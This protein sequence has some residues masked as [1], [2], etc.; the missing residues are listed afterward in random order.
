M[1]NYCDYIT[2]TT[3]MNK[4]YIIILSL[5]LSLPLS[6]QVEKKVIIEHFTNT[7]CG[8]CANKNPALYETLGEYPQLLH[9][10]YHP[11][12][13]Y[14]DCVF[15]MHNP[16]ENDERANYYNVFGGTP[17]A[18][19]QGVALPVQT[20]LVNTSNIEMQLGMTSDFKVTIDNNQVSGDDHKVNVQIERVSVTHNEEIFVYIALAEK[21]ISYNAPNGETM[22]YDVFR[23]K[24]TEE[25]IDLVSVGSMVN[26]VLGYSM[27]PDWNPN[28]IYAYI[29]INSTLSSEVLQSESSLTSISGI[30]NNSVVEV[31]NILYPNPASSTLNINIAYIDKVEKIELY[32]ILGNKVKAFN[33]D[34][35][36]DI[37][38][39]VDGIYFARITDKNSNITSARIIKGQ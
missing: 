5:L 37:S 39:L 33:T 2:K 30:Y 9:I 19:I 25:I 22:H 38:D 18:V 17:R 15:S 13:P 6:A 34:D 21:E 8:I 31:K 4:F 20:P 23:K 29:V 36:M 10:A 24:L 14:A 16:A 28:E 1:L 26:Y 3:K 32:S 12:A 7:K 35:I 11:S 27:H